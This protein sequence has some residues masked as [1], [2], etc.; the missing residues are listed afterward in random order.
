MDPVQVESLVLAVHEIAAN[1]LSQGGSSGSYRV[2]RRPDPVC[3]IRDIGT[4]VE[5][6]A[7]R[8]YPGS[9]SVRGRGLW[10][11]TQLCDLVQVRTRSSGST[12]RMHLSLDN[13]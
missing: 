10:I 11:A 4:I 2:A 13:A 8:G 12:V 9:E 1:S 7:G 3:E 5:P 6:P